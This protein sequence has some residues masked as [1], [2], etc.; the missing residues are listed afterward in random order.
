VCH[1]DKK[2][3]TRFLGIMANLIEASFVSY[4]IRVINDE[5]VRD[6]LYFVY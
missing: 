1:E 6:A 2:G 5:Q 4:Y 3:L